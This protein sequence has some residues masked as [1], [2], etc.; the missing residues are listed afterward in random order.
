[1]VIS[2]TQDARLDPAPRSAAEEPTSPRPGRAVVTS[3]TASVESLFAELYRA[4]FAYVWR[5]ARRLGVSR[6]EADDVVQET[7]VVVH[8]LLGTHE[9]K[10]SPRGWL[11]ALLFRVVQRHRRSHRRR[12]VHTDIDANV[13]I[14]PAPSAG[15]PDQTAE[16]SETIR[17][18]EEILEQLDPDRRAIL[19]LADIEE[20]PV[21][22]I[23]E[24]LGI[25]ERTATSRLRVARAHLDASLAR[26]RARDGWRSNV[27]TD[28]EKRRS[29][30]LLLGS[31]YEPADGDAE[32]VLEKVRSSID[33][34]AAMGSPEGGRG[35]QLGDTANRR[36]SSLG[37]PQASSIV[38]G[39]PLW[40]KLAGV[41]C[42]ALALVGRW[43][44]HED[45]FELTSAPLDSNA[46]GPV[47]TVQAAA[48]NEPTTAVASPPEAPRSPITMDSVP[49]AAL[50]S[51]T[52]KA[53]TTA[54]A[55]AKKPEVAA[56]VNTSTDSKARD[57]RGTTDTLERESQLLGE[58]R[59]ALRGGDGQR[60]LSLLDEHAR[61]FPN[62]WFANDRVVERIVALCGLNRREE[63]V[64]EGKAFLDSHQKSPLT[65][66]I[67]T[68][69]VG[70]P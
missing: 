40:L 36:L 41:S 37:P 45:R 6:A 47:A 44:V 16:T 31:I 32:R 59:H 15:A 33:A 20:R 35:G 50:P 42:V 18:L 14:I 13:D 24:I 55:T 64:R 25:N 54:K 7:F 34:E 38:A 23:A 19:V 17:I 10:G 56:A 68:S 43:L 70:N 12:M 4:E 67:S 60:A 63:A 29:P 48:T 8:R 9:L 2:W 69:C 49:V 65:R 39:V 66:R 1:M 46:L 3:H 27:S 51:A 61:L 28:P 58:A 21:A 62:G 22:E 26:H 30:L 11:F 52:A 53:T 57:D 5:S